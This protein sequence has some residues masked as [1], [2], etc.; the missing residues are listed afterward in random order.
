MSEEKKVAKPKIQ[1]SELDKLQKQFDTFDQKVKDLTQDR[2]AEAPRQETEPETKLSQKEISNSKDIYLKP[3][4][5]LNDNSKFNEKFRKEWEFD[6]EYVSFIAENS[7]T[8]D[9]IEMWTRPYPGVPCQFWKVP[10]GKPVWAPRYVAEQI[11]NCYY[12][13][14]TTQQG[15]TSQEGMGTFYGNLVVDTTIQRLDARPAKTHKSSFV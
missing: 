11:K 3:E 4:R 8:K 10:V 15:V 2:V 5:S 7:E 14:L 13:R 1:E 12:H 9:M 6:K